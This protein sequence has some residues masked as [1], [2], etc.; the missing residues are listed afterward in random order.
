[1]FTY[2]IYSSI[3]S[4]LCQHRVDHTSVSP[5]TNVRR[6]YKIDADKNNINRKFKLFPLV[7]RR[8]VYVHSASEAG[9]N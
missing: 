5:A 3:S 2:Q 4:Y 6:A 7:F 1:M 8:F 9:L